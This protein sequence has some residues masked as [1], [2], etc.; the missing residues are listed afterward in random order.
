MPSQIHN[1]TESRG[2]HLNLIE[3][4]IEKSNE[5]SNMYEGVIKENEC[6]SNV[7][8]IVIN[9]T[10][11]TLDYENTQVVFGGMQ[12][13]PNQDIYAKHA[14][15]IIDNKAVDPT[16]S[17]KGINA[18]TKYLV[19]ERMSIQEYRDYLAEHQHTFPLDMNNKLEQ[20]TLDLIKQDVLLIG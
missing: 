5:F 7:A 9:S 13:F 10:P 17:L 15:F 8:E 11:S 2:V 12:I 1:L 18:G 20:L 4:D 6:Y 19:Y 3:V 16:Q 14:F